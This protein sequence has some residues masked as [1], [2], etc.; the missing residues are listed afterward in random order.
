MLIAHLLDF[1]LDKIVSTGDEFKKDGKDWKIEKIN[2]VYVINNNRLFVCV[3]ASK[4][5]N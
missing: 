5:K 4:I 3:M 1:S 2:S